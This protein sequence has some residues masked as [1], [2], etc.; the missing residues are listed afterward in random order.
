MKAFAIESQAR[1]KYDFYD[2]IAKDAGF[3]GA[4]ENKK[5]HARAEL[6]AYY[7]LKRANLDGALAKIFLMR[8]LVKI[9]N[10]RRCILT[11]LKSRKMK[12]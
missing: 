11:S 1:N 2:D 3:Y 9:I 10:I 7:E 8:L 5:H 6:K 4:V 12:I